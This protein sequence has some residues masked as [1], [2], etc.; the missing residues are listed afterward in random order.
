[1]VTT[2]LTV[3]ESIYDLFMAVN[4]PKRKKMFGSGTTRRPS[5]GGGYGK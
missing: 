3:S 5:G 2:T 4:K 1:M